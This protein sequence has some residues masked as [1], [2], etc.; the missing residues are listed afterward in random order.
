MCC[1]WSGS[2]KEKFALCH[3]GCRFV[4]V[5]AIDGILHL[6]KEVIGDAKTLQGIVERGALAKHSVGTV[7]ARLRQSSEF[8]LTVDAALADVKAAVALKEVR[9][10]HIEVYVACCCGKDMKIC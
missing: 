3:L 2:S 4:H 7:V 8:V 5:G 10:D 9:A 6:A 1:A